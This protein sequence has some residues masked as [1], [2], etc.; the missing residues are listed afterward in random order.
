MSEIAVQIICYRRVRSLEYSQRIVE[1][2]VLVT[3]TYRNLRCIHVVFNYDLRLEIDG[4]SLISSFVFPYGSIVYNENVS[5]SIH[6]SRHCLRFDWFRSF[7]LDK[8]CIGQSMVF[9]SSYGKRS[10]MT[11]LRLYLSTSQQ[12]LSRTRYLSYSLVN[13]MNVRRCAQTIEKYHK[14]SIDE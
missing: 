8:I 12:F 14:Q 10:L 6:V 1:C 13:M 7:C 9:T 2:S 4:K 3:N 11:M 5:I